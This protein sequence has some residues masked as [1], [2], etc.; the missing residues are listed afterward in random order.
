MLFVSI[1][2]ASSGEMSAFGEQLVSC[3]ETPPKASLELLPLSEKEIKESLSFYSDWN[4]ENQILH[5]IELTNFETRIALE[6]KNRVLGELS[7]NDLFIS[8]FSPIYD[9]DR[10]KTLFQNNCKGCHTVDGTILAAPSLENTL[11]NWPFPEAVL[12]SMNPSLAYQVGRS[13]SV[14][15]IDKWKPHFGLMNEQELLEEEIVQI[16][17]YIHNYEA[18][19]GV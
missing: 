15:C 1:G 18:C 13:S 3:E 16:L 12:F 19:G 5:D 4:Y 6:K 8:A 7:K 9:Y 14:N 2:F 11:D 10:G 17:L